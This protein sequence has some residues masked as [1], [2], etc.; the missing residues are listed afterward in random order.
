MG[1]IDL[2]RT[3]VFALRKD[4]PLITVNLTEIEQNQAKRRAAM[5]KANTPAP[6][7]ACVELNRLRSELFNLQQHATDCG[8]RVEQQQ[9]NVDLLETQI[10][11]ALRT[12]KQHEEAGN[13][14]AA[15]N[16]EHQVLRLENELRTVNKLLRLRQEQ[17]S[18]AVRNLLNWKKEFSP[19]LAELTQKKVG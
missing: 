17:N 11:E 10:T 18:A 4:D 12:K 6:K 19:L 3:N 9:G 5:D 13:L 2:V 14:F 7:P 1:F 16:Y 15:R 8:I